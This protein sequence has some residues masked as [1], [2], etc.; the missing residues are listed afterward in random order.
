[1]SVEVRHL[2]NGKKRYRVRWRENGSNRAKVFSVKADADLF[3]AEVTRQRLAGESLAFQASKE[4]LDDFASEWLA[5]V[6]IPNRARA[7][8]DAYATLY[9]AHISPALGGVRLRDLTPEAVQRFA[10]ELRGKTGPAATRKTLV[11]LSAILERAVEWRRITANPAR[12]V[13]KPSQKR[14][15]LV[16]PLAPETIETIRANLLGK[17]RERDALLVSVLGY[18]GPRPGEALAL[19]WGDLRGTVLLIERAVAFGDEKDTK[20]GGARSVTLPA[21]I[22]QE[23]NEYRLSVGRPDDAALIFPGRNGELWNDS[24]YRY[25][26]RKIYVPAAEAA[27]VEHPRPYDLRH[28]AASFALA[29]GRNPVEVAEMLGHSP[30][31]LW[32]TYSHVIRELT[33]TDRIDATE[34]IRKARAEVSVPRSYPRAVSAGQGA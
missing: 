29:E 11:I 3:D 25:W 17:G 24:A 32:G 18:V 4:T 8:A 31:M 1:M 27:G 28:S 10:S 9:D 14:K 12:K 2:A 20:T 13:E 30:Q 33:G 19:R 34:A 26:R 16:R 7:T 22:V 21:P 6:V 23:L 5:A 15:R